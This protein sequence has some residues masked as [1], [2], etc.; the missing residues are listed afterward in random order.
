MATVLQ[1]DFAWPDVDIERDVIEGAGHRLVTG[2]SEPSPAAAVEAMVAEHDPAAIL[3]CWADISAEA[4]RRPTALRIVQRLGVGL[5]NIAM[6]AA[7]ARGT[8]VANVPDY[9]VEEVSDH[10]VA[11]AYAWF[12]GIASFDHA[13]KG[14]KW[15]PSGARLR[16]GAALTA[17]ILG[18]GRIGRCT[19]RK[20]DALGMTVLGHDIAAPPESV[21]ARMVGLDA[22]CAAADIVI[23]PC[24]P[25]YF[26]I[27][28]LD[29]V[30]DIVQ[31]ADAK[32][33]AVLNAIP[34]RGQTANEARAALTAWGIDVLAPTLGHRQAFVHALNSGL[35]VEEYEPRSK[36]AAEVRAVHTALMQRLDGLRLAATG[37]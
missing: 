2:P 4:I 21:P 14:G 15:D 9:C 5:D 28:A 10:A 7:T 8:W 26:D 33:V 27:H 37:S 22:L 18:L 31:L 24:R 3:T 36:A 19:A 20:L 16:R 13:V 1:T 25:S 23:V 30:L 34:P 29:A 35:A 12:R 32:A 17:G 6:E 11:L